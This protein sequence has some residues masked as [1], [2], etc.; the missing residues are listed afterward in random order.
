MSDTRFA[1]YA[2]LILAL[3]AL[4]GAG[5]GWLSAKALGL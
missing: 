1:C 2:A 3:A 4:A 5:L